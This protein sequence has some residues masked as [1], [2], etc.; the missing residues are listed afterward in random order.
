MGSVPE[1][2]R[3]L[4][5]LVRTYDTYAEHVLRRPFNVNLLSFVTFVFSSTAVVIRKH[6]KRG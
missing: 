6:T 2:P 3:D 1:E 4:N 5:V